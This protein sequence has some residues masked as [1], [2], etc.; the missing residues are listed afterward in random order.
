MATPNITPNA[1]NEG[2]LGIS[3][4]QWSE[5]WGQIIYQNGQQV[6]NLASPAFTGTPT[7]PT[8]A[9]ADD[10]TKIATTAWTKAMLSSEG[11]IKTTGA[12]GDGEIPAYDTASDGWQA[13]GTAASFLARANHTGTQAQTTVD[14]NAAVAAPGSTSLDDDLSYLNGEIVSN[15]SAIAGKA[16]ASHSHVSADIS[17]ASSTALPNVIAKYGAGGGLSGI[18]SIASGVAVTGY[19]AA[20]QATGVFGTVNNVEAAGVAGYSAIGTTGFASAGFFYVGG[21][22]TKRTIL[23][24]ADSTNKNDIME[25]GEGT[26]LGWTPWGFITSRG[27]L[28]MKNSGGFYQNVAP[29]AAAVSNEEWSLP[30]NSGA[31]G[32]LVGGAGNGVTDAAAFRT[33]LGVG[34]ADSPVFATVEI[35]PSTTDGI[36]FGLGAILCLENAAETVRFQLPTGGT[37][38]E[39]LVDGDGR[40][41][42]D[43]ALFR[44][45]IG[46]PNIAGDTFTGT[47]VINPSSGSTQLQLTG[48]AGNT[49]SIVCNP[50]A[51]RTYTLPDSTGTFVVTASGAVT[52]GDITDMTATGTAVATAADAAA[53]RTALDC[54]QNE[55][56]IGYGHAYNQGAGSATTV[57][58]SGV[59]YDAA[60]A[61]TGVTFLEQVNFAVP[62]RGSFVGVKYTGS[63]TSKFW[64]HITFSTTVAAA[65][66]S[67][68][69]A[70]GKNGSVV[71]GSEIGRYVSSTQEGAAAVTGLVEL[72]NGN[73]VTLMAQN[74]TSAQNFTI[75]DAT[76]TIRPFEN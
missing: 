54:P 56:S 1:N 33:A 64:V 39:T 23:A 6:A 4:N 35:T 73:D 7:A 34:T 22:H 36:R 8:P 48:A 61:A 29:N 55:A 9:S 3:G 13:A 63:T 37:G 20:S 44:A 31:G 30:V 5:I 41:V 59:W 74:R 58:S 32:T 67:M 71:S 15:A 42:S 60:E 38:N 2:R 40:G 68:Q 57:S 18:A 28:K 47:V 49:G 12:F 16:D 65:N 17:D 27:L 26:A 66:Q 76:I 45:A 11:Y 25:F 19:S 70:V 21:G 50:S 69:F 10:S 14:P 43:A 52:T 46:A 53:A 75:E 51:N 24:L 72:A 62:T